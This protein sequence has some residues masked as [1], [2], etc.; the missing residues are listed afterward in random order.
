LCPDIAVGEPAAERSDA[1]YRDVVLKG[2]L[3]QALVRLNPDLPAEA[4]EDAYRNVFAE[5][6]LLKKSNV[7]NLH[8]ASSDKPVAAHSLDVIISVGYR[9]KSRRGVQFR[10]WA[11]RVRR[12]GI[13]PP[14]DWPNPELAISR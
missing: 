12:E 9:V 13:P 14:C 7:Q 3:R 5:G 2:R 11:T 10:Q 1:N 4:L 6:E 8:I